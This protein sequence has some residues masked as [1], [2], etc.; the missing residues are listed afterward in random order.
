MVSDLNV[1]VHHGG[2]FVDTNGTYV[3][4]VEIKKCDSDE[5]GYF[6]I[7]DIL[8]KLGYIDIGEIWYDFAGQLKPFNDDFAAI[9]AANWARTNGKVDVYVVH[10]ITQPEFVNMDEAQHEPMAQLVNEAQPEPEPVPQPDNET[11]LESEVDSALDVRFDDSDDEVGLNDEMVLNDKVDD[12][13]QGGAGSNKPKNKG[14]RPKKNVDGAPSSKKRKGRPKKNIEVE[15]QVEPILFEEESDEDTL[16][17]RKKEK[18]GVESDE[19]Y[20]SDELESDLESEKESDSEE[21]RKT[22]YPSFVMPKDMEHYKWEAGTLFSTKD[23]FK[24]A[25]RTYSVHSGKNVKFGKNDN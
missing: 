25:I 21:G 20:E 5:W 16:N 6:E 2:E 19:N 22:K 4:F 23:E 11:D 1:H 13:L 15:G 3:G 9:E 7:V 17:L 10:P 8:T 18:I 12:D 24:F 14:G